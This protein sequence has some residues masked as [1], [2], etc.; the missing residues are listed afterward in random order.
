M[1]FCDFFGRVRNGEETL[2]ALLGGSVLLNVYQQVSILM[3]TFM[4]SHFVH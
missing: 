1:A 3:S 4:T 2:L